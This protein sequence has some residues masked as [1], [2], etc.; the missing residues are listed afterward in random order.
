MEHLAF[1]GW[2]MFGEAAV[3]EVKTRHQ[4]GDLACSLENPSV[5]LALLAKQIDEKYD[6]LDLPY[7]FYDRDDEIS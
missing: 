5:G 7:Y 4:A 2:G 6:V 3:E 1:V